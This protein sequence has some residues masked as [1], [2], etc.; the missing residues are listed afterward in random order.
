MSIYYYQP[1]TTFY[2]LLIPFYF[3]IKF[4]LFLSTTQFFQSFQV[5]LPFSC[6]FHSIIFHSLISCFAFSFFK[7]DLCHLSFSFSFSLSFCFCFC[8][9]FCVVGVHTVKKSGCSWKVWTYTSYKRTH[10]SETSIL[11]F[12][13]I[14]CITVFLQNIFIIFDRNPKKCS[15]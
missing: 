2:Y 15:I 1:P 4:S 11:I 3:V 13:S 14:I 5:S 8:F 12:D 9:C 10:Y 7:F 6:C